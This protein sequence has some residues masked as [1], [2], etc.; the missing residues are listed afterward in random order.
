MGYCPYAQRTRLVLAAK[1]IPY[2]TVNVNLVQK[3]EWLFKK[4]REG[5]VPVLEQD[6]M[7]ITESLVTSDYLDE[8]YP[9]N[10]L[11][12][13]DPYLKAKQRLIVEAYSQTTG[14][15]YAIFRTGTPETIA[16]LAETY[17]TKLEKIEKILAQSGKPYFRGDKVG[18][19]DYM[20]FPWFQRIPFMKEIFGSVATFPE[21][22]LPTLA[23]WV[24]RMEKDPAVIACSFEKS[25]L[26]NFLKTNLAGKPVYD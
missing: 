9:D 18:M 4:H 8:A 10:P 17:F 22:K 23:A 11:H 1:K 6:G 5:K 26:L 15:F 25:K 12:P 14:A 21:D 24:R 7:I 19:V 2:E 16:E 20:V 13:S 3:P